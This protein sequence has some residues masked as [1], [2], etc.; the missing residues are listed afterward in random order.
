[1]PDLVH[2]AFHRP[3]TPLHTAV[4]A[5]VWSLIVLSV[6]LFVAEMGFGLELGTSTAVATFDRG[7]LAFF[8]LEYVLRVISFRPPELGVFRLSLPDRAR[9][10]L[11]GRLRFALEPLNLIDL[12]TV[13]ALVPELR[14]LRAIRLLRLLRAARVFRYARPF[15]EV[16]R[17]FED[18]RLLYQLA[19]G[20]LGVQVL[21][22]GASM[23]LVEQAANPEIGDL[24]DGFWW[25]LVTVTTVGFGDISP[26]TPLGRFVGAGVMIGGM[27]TLALFAGIVG[28]TLLRGML[29]LRQEH[30]RMSSYI[31]HVVV[32]GYD[33]G[34]RGL[35]EALLGEGDLGGALVVIAPGERSAGVPAE[36]AWVSGDPTRESELDKVRLAG[37]KA[38]V[39]IAPRALPPQQADAI[40][41]MTIFTLRAWL[42]KRADQVHRRRPLY[43]VAEI[44][45]SENVVHARAAGADEVIETTRLGFSLI[46]HAITMPGTGDVLGRVAT[47]GAHS[48][49]VGPLPGGLA[50]D[51]TFAEAAALLQREHGALAL[52]LRDPDSGEEILN[53]RPSTP[54]RSGSEL[55]YLAVR[56]SLGG[57]DPATRPPEED[58]PRARREPSGNGDPSE[59]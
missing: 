18:S 1:M 2:T 50:D 20:A 12:F 17:A 10:S 9:R 58:G 42:R 19:F 59:A 14:G 3:G 23:W 34:S 24:G 48:L 41:L 52:G 31:D 51:A 57:G 54:L 55:I 11:T 4:H 49:Y 53:P 22:G 15:L 13:L 40:T 32:C 33:E 39:V 28:H 25:A 47:A 30:F 29:G 43:V 35:L 46:A 7:I 36:F 38:A 16:A 6:V 5:V 27:F 8:A 56:A 37:A 44:L 21:V 45:E 26:I